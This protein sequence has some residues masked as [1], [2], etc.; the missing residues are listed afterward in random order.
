M[1]HWKN[2]FAPRNDN[3]NTGTLSALMHSLRE[4]SAALTFHEKVCESPET[5][6]AWRQKVVTQLKNRLQMPPFT[7]EEAPRL[8][9]SAPRNGYT[10]E[11]WEFYPDPYSAVPVLIL[12][13]D[14]IREKVPGVLCCPGSAS[15]KELLAGEEMPENANMRRY[16]FPDRN[17]QA[18]HCVKNGYIAAAIDNPGTGETAELSDDNKETQDRTRL[19]LVQGLINSGRNYLGLSVFQKLRFLEQFRKMPGVDAQNIG[20]MGHSLGAEAALCTALL[21]EKIK[22]LIYNDFVCDSRRRYVAVTEL[23][24]EEIRDDGSW[25]FVPGMWQDF[26]FQDLLAALAPKYLAINESGAEE[27]LDV[28][29]KSYDFHQV[30]D[31]LQ[32]HYY[33]KFADREKEQGAVPLYGLD[34][35]DFYIRYSAVDV[36]DHSFRPEISMA[37]LKKAFARTEENMGS[38]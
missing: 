34:P 38:E 6:A 14:G 21:D 19:K 4:Q 2:N 20:I 13:P 30:P 9:S 32:I 7:E 11:R 29:R 16:K 1:L 31:R 22:V 27:F 15:P 25:H 18:L 24:N 8:L 35:D 12:R 33:P 26:A 17:C 23:K 3:R 5:F 10:L 37:M 36:P 28:I